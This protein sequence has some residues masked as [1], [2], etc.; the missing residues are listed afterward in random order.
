MRTHW[1][2]HV[3]YEG[4]GALAPRLAARGLPL[5]RTRVFA[6]EP[7]PAASDIEFLVVLGGPMS[8]NDEATLPWLAPEKAL[9]REVIVRG[10]P[11]LGI[12]LGAQL[13][14]TAL[15]A[16]V[17]AS[18]E[19]EVGWWPITPVPPP[20]SAPFPVFPFPAAVTALHWHG[21]A[22]ALPGG[23]VP[24]ATSAGC[25]HQALQAGRRAIGLQFHPEADPAWVRTVLAHSPA[26]LRPGPYVMAREDLLADLPERCQQGNAMLDRL[27]EFIIDT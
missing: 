9:I 8:V 27:L 17:G 25:P 16:T 12:C 1:L 20:S 15:G 4:L 22:F 24:L 6:G 26:S 7:L 2:Q 18:P 11:M 19:R 5:Q 23:T 21:E 13:M 3:E 10:T 14:A